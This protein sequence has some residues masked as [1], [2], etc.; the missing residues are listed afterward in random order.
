[1]FT[2]EE[3][4]IFLNITGKISE[5]FQLYNLHIHSK[6]WKAFKSLLTNGNILKRLN[7]GKKSVISGRIFIYL[8]WVYSAFI[9]IKK[10]IKKLL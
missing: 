8:G 1:M 7:K 6:N 10:C 5:N 9:L 2:T 3:K 4:N